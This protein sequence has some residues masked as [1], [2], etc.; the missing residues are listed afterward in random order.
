MD[1]LTKVSTHKGKYPQVFIESPAGEIKFIGLIDEFNVS[2][3][4]SVFFPGSIKIYNHNISIYN[5][6]TLIFSL[7]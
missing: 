1:S 6:C 4:Y 5:N 3:L 2:Y 7:Y